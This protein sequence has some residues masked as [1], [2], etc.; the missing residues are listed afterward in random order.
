MVATIIL[1]VL[2]V[3]ICLGAL[4]LSTVSLRR[5][6]LDDS[7]QEARANAR[8]ALMLAIGELQKEMGP[9]MRVSS[10]A[11]LQDSDTSTSII[12]DVEQPNW[13]AAYNSWGDWL[14]TEYDT[15]DGQTIKITDTYTNHR[16][17]MFRRWLVS[18]PSNARDDIDSAKNGAGLNETNSVV[19]V[20]AGTL[21]KTYS[22]DNPNQIT[23]A[24]LM[25]VRD[26]GRFAWWIGPENHK[27]KIDL[28]AKS[29]DLNADQWAVAQGTTAR[30]AVGVMDGLDAID[31]ESEDTDQL[32]SKMF[33][34]GTL[35]VETIGIGSE[36][37]KSHFFDLTDNSKGIL[38]S[39]RS[40]GLKK[41][42]SLLLDRNNID[43]PSPY[44]YETG[45]DWEPS[46]RPLSSDI[47][48]QGAAAPNRPFASWPAMRHYYRMYRSPSDTTLYGGMHTGGTGAQL[49][50]L[51]WSGTT[52]YTD[53]LS[54]QNFLEPRTNWTGENA[55]MRLPLI[56]KMTFLHSIKTDPNPTVPTERIIRH[57]FSPIVTIWNP[58]NTEMRFPSGRVGI[59]ASINHSWPTQGIIYRDGVMRPGVGSSGLGTHGA[60]LTSD[61][62][63]DIVLKPGELKVF[64]YR[65]VYIHDGT[66]PRYP[67]YPGFDPSSI[68]GNVSSTVRS[69]P[70]SEIIADRIGIK[71]AFDSSWAWNKQAGH[72]PGSLSFGLL[73]GEW[74]RY[75]PN[76]HQVDWFNLSQTATEIT[77]E[78]T[79]FTTSTD[80]V[81]VGYSQIALKS[82]SQPSYESIAW[83]QDWRSRNWI[84]SPPYYFGGGLYMSENPATSH[85]QRLDS[86]YV[87]SFGPA[88]ALEL[89]K[90]VGHIGER[91]FLGSGANP[92]EK[93]TAAPMLELPTAPIS[94]LAGFSG[95]RMSPGWIWGRTLFPDR[96]GYGEGIWMRRGPRTI[97]NRLSLVNAT[98]K[99][100]N[101]QS[102][103]TGPGI[104]NSF[105]HPM[106]P[107][108]NIYHFYDNSVSQDRLNS[109][110][111]PLIVSNTRAY[112]DYW[113]HVFLLND[114]LWDDYYLSTLSNQT[115]PGA[116]SALSLSQNID[117]LTSGE[118]IANSRYQYYSGGLTAAKV[119]LDLQAAE[120]YLK[121]AAH[122]MVDGSFN[123]NS[124]SVAAW[125]ALFAGIRERQIY[126][127][128]ENGSLEE[129]SIPSDAR[130]ALSRFD[131]PNADQEVTNIANGVTR[132]DGNQTWSGVRFLTDEH[133][134]LLAE[135]CVEQVKKRGPFLNF[136]EFINRR[137]SDDEL[138]VMGALQSAIDYDD[139]APDPASINYLYKQSGGLM[140]DESDLGTHEFQT[141]EAAVGSRFAGIPGYVIQSDLLKP[142]ASTLT[143]RDDTFRIRTYGD[144]LDSKGKIRAR[145]WCEAIV[146]RIPDYFD[147]SNSAETPARQQ[148]SDGD[149]EDNP[150]LSDLNRSFGRKFI[151][152][153]FRWL[154]AEE[155]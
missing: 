49:G 54:T 111:D 86:A 36:S 128:T 115:R 138:G 118:P 92:Y 135:K 64:S 85:T 62:G 22:N 6:N 152:V 79:P 8:M 108:T 23:R 51:R 15:P 67:L 102:G 127:R 133:L 121:S 10:Q 25:P 131:T 96:D 12:D 150:V 81:I 53:V 113:D 52:P 19:L 3:I 123:V 33:S 104:G 31:S 134:K 74:N 72:T 73:W 137:L 88:S 154:N 63:A 89:P 42:L 120:G 109:V 103:I 55:Y 99:R 130:I 119:K 114:A 140:L 112:S 139:N 70:T 24:F 94:S 66:N 5:S 27:A 58:Y 60:Y 17:A 82:L 90:V 26:K 50:S 18:L 40:G 37:A 107:R 13:L 145:A 59:P 95:M 80:P 39:V 1:M 14:N 153:S 97:D 71:I 35:S 11:A 20:G 155:I 46:I 142:I 126:Y 68:G 106:I 21:G 76:L 105:V 16:S 100:V 91:A 32:A 116:P 124:T 75:L 149:F 147:S 43:L 78:I 29:R 141:P 98:T 65:N 9:D 7:V 148:N 129:V 69:Y 77:S 41:D 34:L 84:H 83:E 45:A 146:Q 57:L 143:V 117:R 87:I 151:V 44:R 47:L 28:A 144:S 4:S 136:S 2:L 132:D 30:V 122:L 48:A 125:Y 56:A 38:T 110:S 101:Y 93:V 61:S